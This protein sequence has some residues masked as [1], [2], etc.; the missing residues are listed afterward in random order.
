MLSQ[1]QD[2]LS[3]HVGVHNPLS[4]QE[5]S[6]RPSFIRCALGVTES[7]TATAKILAVLNIASQFYSMFWMYLNASMGWGLL[8]GPMCC[9]TLFPTFFI[10]ERDISPF[11]GR[12]LSIQPSL[13][14]GLEWPCPVSSFCPSPSHN[15]NKLSLKVHFQAVRFVLETR[16][17]PIL[18]PS[19]LTSTWASFRAYNSHDFSRGLSISGVTSQGHAYGKSNGIS[20]D[21]IITLGLPQF[22]RLSS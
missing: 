15:P 6:Q 8:S 5:L 21:F 22:T 16:V 20:V 17:T 18:T 1:D 12:F 10:W 19:Q 13:S 11:V 14:G 9:P 2:A 4:P 7:M 3:S